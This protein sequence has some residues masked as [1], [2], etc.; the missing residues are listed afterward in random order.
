ML[1]TELLTGLRLEGRIGVGWTHQQRPGY[2]PSLGSHSAHLGAPV[3]RADVSLPAAA[4][5][6]A[7]RFDRRFVQSVLPGPP[8]LDETRLALR[9]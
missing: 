1:E 6:L 3:W 2:H 5:D 9:D 8:A 4:N 7:V